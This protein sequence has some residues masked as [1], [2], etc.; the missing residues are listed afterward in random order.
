MRKVFF[1]LDFDHRYC[2][3]QALDIILFEHDE[4]IA[5]LFDIFELLFGV[6]GVG[7]IEFEGVE[8]CNQI[9]GDFLLLLKPKG[10]I[11]FIFLFVHLIAKGSSIGE[12]NQ[13]TVLNDSKFELGIFQSLDIDQQLIIFF[14]LVD[15]RVVEIAGSF[16]AFVRGNVAFALYSCID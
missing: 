12:F 7:D 15:E 8:R 4:A 5:A 13:G 1:F 11:Y 3:I 9:E 6:E 10:Q 16:S 14:G 2:K